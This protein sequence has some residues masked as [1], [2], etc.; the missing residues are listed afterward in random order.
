MP[1]GGA[2]VRASEEEIIDSLLVSRPVIRMHPVTETSDPQS[3]ELFLSESGQGKHS[4]T[5]VLAGAGRDVRPAYQV[6][7]DLQHLSEALLALP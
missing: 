6:G 5:Y 7:G 1:A 3:A 2:D 4:R